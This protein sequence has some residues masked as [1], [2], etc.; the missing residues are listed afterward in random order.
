MPTQTIVSHFDG[1]T[2]YECEAESL[3]E[4]LQNAV[5]KGADLGGAD[6]RGSDLWGSDLR[7]AKLGY[8]DLGH[9]D[10]GHADLG[11]A[12]LRYT[13]LGHADLRGS[14][15]RSAYLGYAKLGYADLRGAKLNWQSH[16]L[17]AEILRRAAAG[18]VEKRMIAG[19]V[20]VSIDWCWEKFLCIE[21]EQKAWALATLAKW[22]QDGDGAPEALRVLKSAEVSEHE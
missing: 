17:L 6:L 16:A 14:D 4:A 22:V 18:D 12:N 9:A 15:L 7:G 5:K 1:R 13:D 8:A 3:L 2:L 10:L 11:Y 21:H 19:L 20:A